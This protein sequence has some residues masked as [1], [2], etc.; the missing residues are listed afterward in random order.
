MLEVEP[1]TADPLPRLTSAAPSPLEAALIGHGITAAIAAELV[2]E[3]SEEKVGLQIEHL[4]WMLEKKPG[5]V[6][7]PAAWLCNAIRAGIALP[8]SFV[9]KAERERRAEAKKAADQKAAEEKRRQRQDEASEKAE[10]KG[11]DAYWASQTPEQQAEIDA[12]STA[13]ADAATLAMETGPLKS[14]GQTLRRH[15]Y[16]RQLLRDRQ[17]AE[18]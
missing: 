3:H 5:K 4:E 10:R 7:E 14:M 16:I 9:S 18:S 13:Q 17:A 12:A 2:R 1:L 15:A 8:K 11:I 6:S